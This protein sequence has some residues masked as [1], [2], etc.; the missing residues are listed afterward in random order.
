[1]IA[2]SDKQPYPGLRPF[3]HGD[4]DYFFGREAQTRALREKLKVSRLIAVVGRSGCGKSSLVRAGIVPLLDRER[5]ANGAPNWRIATFRPQGQPLKQLADELLRLKAEGRSAEPETAE[6]TALRR[7]R[8]DAMLRRNSL[9]LVDAARELN[10]SPTTGLLII[11]DQFEEIFRFDGAGGSDSDEATA[12]VRLLLATISAD[13]PRIYVIL[14]MRLDFLGDCARF[15]GL[16]EALSEGQFLVPNLSRVE[17]RAA[18]EEPAKKCGAA[19]SPAVTQ[20]LLNEIGED[21]DRLPVLQ[22][23]LMRTWQAAKGSRDITLAHYDSTGGVENAISRHADEVYDGLPSD[24][25]RRIAEHMF[26]AISELDRRGRAI[27]RPLPLGEIGR[28]ADAHAD[29]VMRVIDTF[30]APECC[31]LMPPAEVPLSQSA[32]IDISHESL[33]RGWRKLTGD[34]PGE[35]WLLEEDRDGRTYHNLV[36][37]AKTFAEDASAV[38]SPTQARARSAW[39]AAL[40]PNAAWAE[41]YEGGFEQVQRLLAASARRANVHRA[42]RLITLGVV[43]MSLITALGV[44]VYQKNLTFQESIR[45]EAD[46]AALNETLQRSREELK[47]TAA[48]RQQEV[49]KLQAENEQL[50]RQFQVARPDDNAQQVAQ[51]SPDA[52]QA[53]ASSSSAIANQDGYIW[54][55]S[56]QKSNLQRADGVPVPPGEVRKGDRYVVTLNIYLRSGLPDANYTQQPSVGVVAPDTRIEALGAPTPFRRGTVDQFWLPVRVL[57]SDSVSTVYFQYTTAAQRPQ[58]QALS[59]KLQA[60]GYKVPDED[61]VDAAQGK[62]EVRYFYD[63]DKD[64]AVKLAADTTKAL[65]E[66]GLPSN[67][68]VTAKLLAVISKNAQGIIEL[69]V[70]LTAPKAAN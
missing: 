15:Q 60:L 10:L 40:H 8:M 19:V 1:M 63:Q 56:A 38:L 62:R 50:R 13:S 69:W 30:R 65:Q 4:E 70:D 12:F 68:P 3:D 36:E 41:R 48:A 43:A 51:P 17:R 64:A 18:I 26:K 49:D 5:S 61:R 34:R 35:G 59:K 37:A 39:W 46:V 6:T 55:G 23:V 11:V 47:T 20:R 27:R 57:T 44:F 22:H 32:L 21:P 54:I 29:S 58:A 24:Q 25:H 53:G 67:P 66:M 31:F 28:V 14:T 9:G 52:K 33:L 42:K 7:S 2:L 16:P 45:R